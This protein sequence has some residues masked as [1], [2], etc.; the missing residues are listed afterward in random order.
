MVRMSI[1]QDRRAAVAASILFGC[2]ATGGSAQPFISDITRWTDQDAIDAPAPGS[3]LFIGSSSIRRWEQLCLDFADYRVIQRGFGGAQYENVVFYVDDIVLP[4]QPE[5][6]VVWAGTNDNTSGETGQEVF[7]DHRAFVDAVHAQQPDVKILYLGITPTPSNT[8]FETEREIANTLIAADA[9]TD[10]R[11]FYIDLPA[12]FDA[13]NPPSGPEFTALYV[14]PVHLNRAGY[15]LWTSVTRPVLLANVTPDKPLASDALSPSAGTSVFVDFGPADVTNGNATLGPDM[16]GNYWNNWY[17]IDGG[18]G[19]NAGERLAGL[20]DEDNNPTGLTL[21]ITGGFVVNGI[22][23]GALLAPDPAL[24]GELAV[25]TATQDYFFSQ[26]DDLVGGGDD[27]VPGSFKISGLDPSIAHEFR[28][29]GSRRTTTTRATEYLVVGA[30]QGVATLQTS[31]SN[32]GADGAYDGNDDEIAVVSGILPN[33]FGEVFVDLTVA[34]GSFAYINAMEI[35]AGVLGIVRD[36]SDAIVEAGGTLGFDA[37]LG[38]S[39]PGVSL[40]WFRD[41]VALVDGDGVSGSAT[42]SLTIVSADGGDVG[43][44]TLRASLGGESV[45]SRPAIGAVRG[46][47]IGLD[48]NNDGV[49]DADDIAEFLSIVGDALGGG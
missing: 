28:F 11:L 8:P 42:D 6:I 46:S 10:P 16:N 24:L 34:G 18:A 49:R 7:E 5:A 26:A 15:G 14:D 13:L 4:Y 47:G 40:R 19:I 44:Y 39:V 9:A 1:Q 31:G 41:G 17:P 37:E 48:V 36:P 21:T 27:D 22:L 25:A 30:N 3:V 35:R 38:T 20:V 2:G 32:I 43:L 45:E 12:A 23:N 33:E 29:F